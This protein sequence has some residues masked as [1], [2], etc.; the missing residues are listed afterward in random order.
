MHT[1]PISEGKVDISTVRV[2]SIN[3][4]LQTRI[5]QHHH[6]CKTS[7]TNLLLRP[8]SV[9]RSPA[10]TLRDREPPQIAEGNREQRHLSVL[11]R[12][13]GLFLSKYQNSINIVQGSY[14]NMIIS[15]N[16]LRNL[17]KSHTTIIANLIINSHLYF[18]LQTTWGYEAPKSP[19][20]MPFQKFTNTAS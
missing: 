14:R 20:S 10:L 11:N 13:K 9:R 17:R 2:F 15:I 12:G 6:C 3:I 1:L 7:D 19:K 8:V 18:H 5:L 16:G 4:V